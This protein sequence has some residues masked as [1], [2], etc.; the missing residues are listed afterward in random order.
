MADNR[1]KPNGSTKLAVTEGAT[2]VR[3]CVLAGEVSFGTR[4]VVHPTAQILAEKGPIIIGE[5]NLIEE[6]VKIVN[7]SEEPLI[8][9]NHNV[10]EVGAVVQAR[11]VGDHNT[12]ECLSLV[13][14]RV[15]VGNGCTVG[16]GCHISTE[17][18][19]GDDIVVYGA[20]CDR[21]R[22]FD[23]NKASNPQ[24]D[25]LLKVMVNYHHVHKPNR[26]KD[27][28]MIEAK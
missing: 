23:V 25:F 14:P 17:E 20:N 15:A 12:F 24:I 26:T 13:G 11:S 6:K 18:T 2:V 8:I 7:N 10:F 27:G 21:K 3:E 28:Q 22:A 5:G 9:G 19:L 4:T 16:A 1:P